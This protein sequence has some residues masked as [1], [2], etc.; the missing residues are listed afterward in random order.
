MNPNK[1]VI[2]CSLLTF[3]L[4]VFLGCE[5][6]AAKKRVLHAVNPQELL[7]E[8]GRSAILRTTNGYAVIVPFK[9]TPTKTSYQV[10]F[11]TSGNFGTQYSMITQGTATVTIPLDIQGTKV[12]LSFGGREATS[13]RLDF[14][15]VSTGVA[16]LSNTNLTQIDVTKVTFTF[17]KPL[18]P[19]DLTKSIGLQ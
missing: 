16:L 12:Y 19:E 5:R 14:G 9:P 1:I 3:C 13:I 2:T 10:F 17:G 4:L 8:N 6:H 11:S 7:V 18:K 15:D